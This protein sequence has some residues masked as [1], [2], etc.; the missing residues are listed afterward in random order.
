MRLV[1]PEQGLLDPNKS[2]RKAW[3]LKGREAFSL[4]FRT[5][6]G[7]GSSLSNE[8]QSLENRALGELI[9]R[10]KQVLGGWV[11]VRLRRWGA[12]SV[13]GLR[14]EQSSEAGAEE[15]PGERRSPT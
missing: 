2:I 11:V 1:L 13:G 7:E 9:V 14:G 5:I 3:V 6:P 12:A 8:G 10:K 15:V 4:W